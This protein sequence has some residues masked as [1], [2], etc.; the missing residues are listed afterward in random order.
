MIKIKKITFKISLPIKGLQKGR[1]YVVSVPDNATFVESLAMVDKF[2]AEHPS[3]SIFPLYDGY[4]HNFIQLMWNPEENVIYD[5]VGVF[6][7]G[8]DEE[9][10]CRRFMPIKED[11]DFNLYPDSVIDLQPDSGC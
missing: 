4:I 3:E 9:G 11:I 8:P 2:V 10:L 5:D 7:Y 1:E 6:P